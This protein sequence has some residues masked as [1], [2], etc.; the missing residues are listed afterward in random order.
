MKLRAITLGYDVFQDDSNLED[1]R[2]K[3][4]DLQLLKKELEQIF[5]VQYIRLATP[6]FTVETSERVARDQF[7]SPRIPERLEEFVSEGLLDIYSYCPG[8]LDHPRSMQPGQELIT[9][10]L[11]EMLSQN[12]NMFSSLQV[13]STANGIN[14]QAI[15]EA[16]KVVLGLAQNDPFTNVQFAVTF[17][18]PGNTPFF[19]SAYHDPM[20]GTAPKISLALEAADEL[21]SIFSNSD[22]TTSSLTD[23]K[24]AIQNRF[25]KISNDLSSIVEPFCKNH[26]FE[27]EG[28]DFSPAPYPTKDKSIGNALEKL[29]FT[30]FGGVG[31]VF[32]VGFITQ[33]LQSISSPKIGFSGFMQPLLEDYIIAQRNNEGKV[34]LSKLLLYSTMCGLGLDCVPIPGNT[35]PDAVKMLLLDLG[36]IS[37]RLNKPLTARLMPIPQKVKGE[38]TEFDFE[39]FTDSQIC[40]VDYYPRKEW[41]AFRKN[42]NHYR[43]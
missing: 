26:G 41:V 11:V 18:V 27:F 37:M 31:S 32:S 6:P 43:F 12:P 13:G 7:L 24:I 38:M 4:E 42:N 30:E 9:N 25:T 39:Y 36:M 16:T 19:P 20:A 17:N 23:L 5:D 3:L 40:G 28:I 10:N 21:V 33:A 34:D 35:S 8:L 29:G 1:V 14:F 22:I 2:E 15:D